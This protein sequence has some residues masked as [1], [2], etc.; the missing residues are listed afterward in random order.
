[1]V[2]TSKLSLNLLFCCAHGFFRRQDLAQWV[3]LG[4]QKAVTRKNIQAGFRELGIQSLNKDA[5]VDKM[6]PSELFQQPHGRRKYSY[7]K[8]VED[9]AAE[10]EIDIQIEEIQLEGILSPPKQQTQYF[11]S[12]EGD[13]S[14]P[15]IDSTMADPDS[16]HP[17]S[18]FLKLPEIRGTRSNRIRSESFVDYSNS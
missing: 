6:G 1:M 13:S 8:D 4:L 2:S 10:D 9:E 7:E 3:S 17:F 18:Q 12:L 16:A 15:S 14:C 11:V 5:M